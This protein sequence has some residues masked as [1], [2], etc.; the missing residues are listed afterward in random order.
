MVPK[1]WVFVRPW[2]RREKNRQLDLAD[3][4]NQLLLGRDT[5]WTAWRKDTKECVGCA[6]TSVWEKPPQKIKNPR[7]KG[8][9]GR[10]LRV[11]LVGGKI[12][13]WIDSAV[14]RIARYGHEQ[15]CTILFLMANLHWRHYSLRFWN[16]EWDRVAISRDV[17]RDVS[18]LKGKTRKFVNRNR[19]GY[20]RVF[21]PVK[22]MSKQA[23][24]IGSLY[25]FEISELL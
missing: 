14:E 20:Y 13:W 9:K 10:T 24:N 16:L 25:P 3:I 18:T 12:W 15:K 6:I 7:L 22:K 4:R 21:T 23:F 8:V 1:V 5:L 17:V 19:I 2:L 11:H